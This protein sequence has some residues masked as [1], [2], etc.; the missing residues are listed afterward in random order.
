MLKIF[1]YIDDYIMIMKL[2]KYRMCDR[3]LN[4]FKNYLKSRQKYIEVDSINV[5]SSTGQT[6]KGV[7]QESIPGPLLCNIFVIDLLLGDDN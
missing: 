6:V 1:D 3:T 5:Q 4:W 7:P 2:K